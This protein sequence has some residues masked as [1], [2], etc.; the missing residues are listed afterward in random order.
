MCDCIK[1]VN[2]KLK[3]RNTELRVP[4]FT[5]GGANTDRVFVMTDQIET[6]RG[7]QKAVSMFASYCPFCGGKY[8]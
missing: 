1:I 5:M 2:E 6:G 8:E 4:L 7:K 3:E